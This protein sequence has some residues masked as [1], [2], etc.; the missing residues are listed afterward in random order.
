MNIIKKYIPLLAI[1]IS[2]ALLVIFRSVPTGHVWEGYTVLYVPTE[3]N[4]KIVTQAFENN[5]IK[6]YVALGNQRVPVL[7]K[8]DSVEAAMLRLNVWSVYN[9]YLNARENYFYDQTGAYK[10]FY[11]P[12]EYKNNIDS[13]IRYLEKNTNVLA[14]I[15]S[16]FSYPWLLP[17][18]VILLTIMLAVF[19]KNKILFA[20]QM[21]IPVIYV[22]CNPFYASAVAVIISMISMFFISNLWDRENALK[23]LVK[24]VLV[25]L[26]QVIAL[27]AAFSSSIFSGIF[28]VLAFAGVVS[29]I[30][31]YKNVQEWRDKK[32]PFLPVYIKPAKMVSV[33]GG[34]GKIVLPVL[35]GSIVIIL[36]YF[37][38]STSTTAN[39]SNK[40]IWIP[41]KS[42]VQAASLPNLEDYYR[43]NWNVQTAPYRSLNVNNNSSDVVIFP[44]FVDEN[45]FVQENDSVLYYNENFKQNAY[46]QID[47]LDFDSIEKV[48]KSQGPEF[49]CG[50][51]TTGAYKISL[52]SVIMMFVCFAMLLFIYFSVMIKK[53]GRK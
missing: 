28:F 19:A 37:V 23:H 49:N 32:S 18:I 50:Y 46:N 52:F 20:V 43:F 16:S 17:I 47:S 39:I 2:I 12:N 48:I 42:S 40:K 15:D 24:G 13:C 22:F 44:S 7:L 8:T 30:I 41:G 34:N 3:I 14:G 10:L 31:T 35:L 21:I 33:Y 51:V 53:G 5:G 29:V 1:A 38:F 27:V 9:E 25:I 36:I 26:I 4:E 45:G 11:I 6:E